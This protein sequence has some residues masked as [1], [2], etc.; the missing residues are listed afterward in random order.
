MQRPVDFLFIDGD[1]TYDGVRADFEM[2]SPFVS[3]GGIVAFHDIA[4]HPPD[5]GCE[6]SRYWK[7]IKQQYRHKEII[8]DPRQ[9]WAGLGVL[10]V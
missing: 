4:D 6:V 3:D 8:E 9:G 5:A 2:Y 1:H 10:Y 7:E